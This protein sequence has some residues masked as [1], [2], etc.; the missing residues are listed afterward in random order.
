MGANHT[1]SRGRLIFPNALLPR[2]QTKNSK[3]CYCPFQCP[4]LPGDDKVIFARYSAY[5]SVQMV[6][7]YLEF[8]IESVLT[9]RRGTVVCPPSFLPT[10]VSLPGRTIPFSPITG[11]IF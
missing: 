5:V 6:P 1:E 4:T 7:V 11:H 9:H 8:E 3:S 10:N 2:Q